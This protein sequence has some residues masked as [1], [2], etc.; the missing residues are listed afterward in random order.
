MFVWTL[1]LYG[2]LN[3]MMFLFLV[4]V[5][6]VGCGDEY[7]RVGG[8]PLTLRAF[9]YSGLALLNISLF[10]ELSESLLLIEFGICLMT[11]GGWFENVLM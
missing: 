3:Q 5:C 1:A 2:G 11:V 7:E 10:D 4:L 9:S 6:L 8:C